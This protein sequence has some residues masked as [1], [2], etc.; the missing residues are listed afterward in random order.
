MAEDSGHFSG[1]APDWR[2]LAEHEK[3][4]R[5]AYETPEGWWDLHGTVG[6]LHV[7]NRARV[8]YF[9]EK[10][11]G[12]AGKRILDVGCGGGILSESLAGE[13]A[14]VVAVD[15]SPASIKVA[16]EHS[17][18]RG[19]QID[20]RVGFAEEMDFREEFDVVFA[21]DVLEHVQD[22]ATSIFASARAL[23]PG[24]AFGFLTHNQT[25][26]AFTFMIWEQEY[27]QRVMPKGAHD[28]HKFITPEAMRAALERAGLSGVEI[29]GLSRSGS[30]DSYAIEV[31]DDVSIS[32]LGLAM[33]RPGGA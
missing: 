30:G 26:E 3:Y 9:K 22:L 1:K 8:A 4:E 21:V 14:V 28:F 27:R 20:Y 31:S 11:G 33:K 16:R 7:L 10:L 6:G 19:L 25:L 29:R 18:S 32:Y 24:G 15:P 13:G 5:F 23:K 12:F 2:G 17:L